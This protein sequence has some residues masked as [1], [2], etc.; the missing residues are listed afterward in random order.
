MDGCNGSK[1]VVTFLILKSPKRPLMPLQSTCPPMCRFRMPEVFRS[2]V[3]SSEGLL[4]L[5]RWRLLPTFSK[6]ANGI[7]GSAV[8]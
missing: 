8:D 2:K 5:Q 4:E 1:N 7:V 3:S 6:L